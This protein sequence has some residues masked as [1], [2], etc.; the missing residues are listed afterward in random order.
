M[1]YFKNLF[2]SVGDRNMDDVLDAIETTLGEQDIE[3]LS[4]DFTGEE[5][6]AALFQM[7]PNKAPG[8]NGM[9]PS[10]FQNFWQIVGNDIIECCLNFLNHGV[11]PKDFN[12]TDIALIPK[13]TNPERMTY[14]RPISLCNVVY[15][16][17]SKCLANRIKPLL[18]SL[19]Y[20]QQSAFIPGRLIT[21]NILMAYETLNCLRKNKSENNGTMAIKLDMSKAYDQVE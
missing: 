19:I 2:K 8:P 12:V 16:I 21:D 14:L 6:Q 15:K 3:I 9:S 20:D 13:C 7:H 10:F 4:R 17:M 1:D 5:V 18:H 11:M